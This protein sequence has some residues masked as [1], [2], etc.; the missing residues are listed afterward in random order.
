MPF[1]VDCASLPP[2]LWTEWTCTG[3]LSTILATIIT[4]RATIACEAMIDESPTGITHRQWNTASGFHKNY[5]QIYPSD[6]AGHQTGGPV[7]TRTTPRDLMQSPRQTLAF[8]AATCQATNIQ[9][10]RNP[11]RGRSWRRL[12]LIGAMRSS[13]SRWGQFRRRFIKILAI[14]RRRITRRQLGDRQ[15]RATAAGC[16]LTRPAI[17][18]RADHWAIGTEGST[19]QS[20]RREGSITCRQTTSNMMQV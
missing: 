6:R 5:Q 14:H 4:R 15:Q 19:I 9:L 11:R 2:R 10:P 16:T 17:P 3:T 13:S 20:T 12:I 7:V 8:T 1:H 18:G